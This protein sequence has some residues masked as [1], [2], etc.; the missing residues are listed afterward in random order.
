M[1]SKVKVCWLAALFAAVGVNA[2]T[3]SFP[4][5]C[6]LNEA[7]VVP[8][9]KNQVKLDEP[10]LCVVLTSI[11]DTVVKSIGIGRVTNIENTEESGNGVVIFAKVNGKGVL[12]YAQHFSKALYVAALVYGAVV[13]HAANVLI[14]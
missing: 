11:P 2:Q 10:D 1:N 8:P 7:T 13:V 9:P 4:L 6:P 5:V 14:F 3:N 12:L